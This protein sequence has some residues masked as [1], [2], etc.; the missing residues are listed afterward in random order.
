MFVGVDDVSQVFQDQVYQAANV[1]T[2]PDFTNQAP[3]HSD[4]AIIELQNRIQ[5]TDGVEKACLNYQNQHYD[6][7]IASGFGLTSPPKMNEAGNI[8]NNPR[9]TNKLKVSLDL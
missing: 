5:F 2:H 9:D 6:Y 7:L 1:Y 8:V 4:V 3:F